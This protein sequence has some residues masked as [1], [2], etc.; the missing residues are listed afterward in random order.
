M[1]TA[2][3]LL[4][5]LRPITLDELVARAS[6]LTRLDRKYILPA[7]GLPAVLGALP[8]DV[9]VLEIDR[10]RAF[11][12]RSAYFDT[13]DLDGYLAAAHRRRRRFKIR[14]RSYVD[15][16][17][18]FAE[19]KTRGR[20]GTTVKQRISYTGDGLHLGSEARAYAGAVLAEAAIPADG[21]H[22]GHVLTTRYRRTTLFVPS[23]GSRVTIDADLSW[24]LPDGTAIRT[25]ERVIV[26]TKS[27]RTTSQI[28]RLLWSLGHRP[29]SVS[30]YATGLAALRPDLP[31]N[32]W[33]PVLRRHFPTV[34][35]ESR[36]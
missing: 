22:F 34:T 24:A 16:G 3:A 35:E 4:D 32:R 13:P 18:H 27:D 17:T 31:A 1:T 15:S 23:T 20:R 33:R 5:P 36:P 21:L 26:E 2:T 25:P 8:A 6:L 14:I 28:D 19:V 11:G 30:K 9:R 7:A 29:C 12:Y 10:R